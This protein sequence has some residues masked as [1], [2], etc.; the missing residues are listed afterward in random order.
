MHWRVSE[1]G[2]AWEAVGYI[3]SNDATGTIYDQ[4]LGLFQLN[5]NGT[6]PV[7]ASSNVDGYSLVGWYHIHPDT[8]NWE[9]GNG[10][11]IVT[12]NHFSP[13]DISFS[14][15]DGIPGYVA[16]YNDVGPTS[17]DNGAMQAEESL[18]WYSYN[19]AGTPVNG[20]IPDTAKGALTTA[21]G[22]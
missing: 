7:P 5:A 18:Q 16:E 12:G 4:Y 10:I 22:C 13:A 3:Y 2:G 19:P 14:A 21:S 20:K 6:T 11:D 15:S 17:L 8:Y 1:S 9:N